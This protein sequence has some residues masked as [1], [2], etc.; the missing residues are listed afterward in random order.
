MWQNA[1]DLRDKK[2][3]E[4]EVLRK[5]LKQGWSL[6]QDLIESRV[7]Q[8]L[9]AHEEAM[10]NLDRARLASVQSAAALDTLLQ[11]KRREYQEETGESRSVYCLP[12]IEGCGI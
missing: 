3:L 5:Q 2:N 11:R 8:Y 12:N 1:L 6:A 4:K 10:Q 9:A 7:E